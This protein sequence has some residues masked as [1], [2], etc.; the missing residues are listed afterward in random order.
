MRLDTAPAGAVETR[1]E[2]GPTRVRRLLNA[3]DKDRHGW[4]GRAGHELFDLIC[5]V[6]DVQE[7][8]FRH[9]AGDL[10]G[11]AVADVWE[12][13]ERWR[14]GTRSTEPAAI[15]YKQAQRRT[16]SA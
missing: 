2:L 3:I 16:A 7:R 9:A 5:D 13:L 11:S 12:A 1:Q 10:G 6:V 4:N 8:R 15:L 14:G